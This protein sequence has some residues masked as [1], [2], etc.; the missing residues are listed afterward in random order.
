MRGTVRTPNVCCCTPLPCSALLCFALLLLH[1][2]L[3][4]HLHITLTLTIYSDFSDPLP[5]T[6]TSHSPPQYDFVEIMACPSGCVNGG[7]QLK[8]AT[9]ARTGTGT[10]AGTDAG[11]K[12]TA[13]PATVATSGGSGGSSGGS[14]SGGGSRES[15]A[16]VRSR[17]A[18]VEELIHS[19]ATVRRPELSPLVAYVYPQLAV[20]D[21]ARSSHQ[22]S[23]ALTGRGVGQE[24]PL[25]LPLPLKSAV[26]TGDAATAAAAAAT[27]PLALHT[28]YHAVPKLEVVAPLVTKW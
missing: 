26:P 2:H 12:G 16:E 6:L 28:R 5:L 22:T 10:G 15:P 17:V 20:D 3:Y 18:A 23:G 11:S 21:A 9:V 13:A 19:G 24:L 25:P 27:P 4:F 1:F 7:G 14:S 8:T